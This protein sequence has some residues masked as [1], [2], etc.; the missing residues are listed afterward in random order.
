MKTERT[1][2]MGTANDM[3][4]MNE[5]ESSS[6]Y[7]YTYVFEGKEKKGHNNNSVD[8]IGKN[9]NEGT[10]VCYPPPRGRRKRKISI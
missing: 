2:K 9:D 8:N 4:E 10:N 1:R 5:D 6:S 7:I 3:E